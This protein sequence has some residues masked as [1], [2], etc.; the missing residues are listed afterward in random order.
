MRKE[1]QIEAFLKGIEQ[2]EKIT[3]LKPR[4]GN[5]AQGIFLEVHLLNRLKDRRVHRLHG[6]LDRIG[7]QGFDAISGDYFQYFFLLIEQLKNEIAKM[8][9]SI[10]SSV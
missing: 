10:Y 3:D 4:N 5:R 2:M 8:R 6:L 9:F 7:H 1:T